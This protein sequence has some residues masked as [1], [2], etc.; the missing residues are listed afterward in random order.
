[1]RIEQ[2]HLNAETGQNSHTLLWGST[3]PGWVLLT[4]Y[5]VTP[6]VLRSLSNSHLKKFNSHCIFFSDGPLLAHC[7]TSVQ[8]GSLLATL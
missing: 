2:Q 6:A 5:D 8:N 7:D 3:I 4:L 1:M